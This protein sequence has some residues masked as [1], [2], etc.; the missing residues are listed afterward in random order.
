MFYVAS[1]PLPGRGAAGLPPSIWQE[2]TPEGAVEWLRT[3]AMVFPGY[4]AADRSA[5]WEPVPP[6]GDDEDRFHDPERPPYQ[7]FSGLD[8][9]QAHIVTKALAEEVMEKYGVELGDVHDNPW[10]VTY[11]DDMLRAIVKRVRGE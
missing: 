4:W 3:T 9:G 10:I 1:K 8:R 2:R 11:V 6:A 7:W 5:G